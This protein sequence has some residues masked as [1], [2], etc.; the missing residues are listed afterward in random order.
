M[1]DRAAFLRPI[2]HR[3]LHDSKR[4]II[5]NTAPAFEAALAKGY[6]GAERVFTVT[7]DGTTQAWLGSAH[8][9]WDRA[10]YEERLTRALQHPHRVEA[11]P[12]QV[13]EERDRPRE[14]R[15]ALPVLDPAQPEP[16]EPAHLVI[17]V[18]RGLPA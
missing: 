13:T 9:T 6:G 2:A 14:D 10:A 18:E 7:S 5:E 11:D 17:I 15:K 12:R 8:K 1:L 4:G 16:G 3:G